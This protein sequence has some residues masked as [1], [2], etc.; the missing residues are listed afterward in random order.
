MFWQN[1]L[2]LCNSLGQSPNAVAA[3]CGV[4]SSGTVSNWKNGATP[5]DGILRAIADYF[6]VEPETLI[7]GTVYA[8]GTLRVSYGAKE[9]LS[10]Y[11]RLV[12]ERPEMAELLDCA[13][14]LTEEEI[15]GVVGML[16]AFAGE[17]RL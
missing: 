14:R 10:R 5:R 6:A 13:G 16:K 3:K 4:R 17:K 1:Y 8:D 9:D 2:R 12:R 11:Y 7:S 15:K